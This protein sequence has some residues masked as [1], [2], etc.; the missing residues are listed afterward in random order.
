[1]NP[2]SSNTELQTDASRTRIRIDKNT[3]TCIRDTF[4]NKGDNVK[5]VLRRSFI[6]FQEKVNSSDR[7]LNAD[8]VESIPI[9]ICKDKHI[10]VLY[11]YFLYEVNNVT[12]VFITDIDFCDGDGG[13]GGGG[14]VLR[15]SSNSVPCD[16]VLDL[17][18][19]HRITRKLYRQIAALRGPVLTRCETSDEINSLVKLIIKKR[20]FALRKNQSAKFGDSDKYID[21]SELDNIESRL[22][23]DLLDALCAKYHFGY[24]KLIQRRNSKEKD[25]VSNNA[26]DRK[27]TSTGRVRCI[28]SISVRDIVGSLVQWELPG[29]IP[30][31]FDL[32]VGV[33]PR[34]E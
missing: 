26:V 9:Q 2:S 32:F 21:E 6:K 12:T 4:D 34:L 13:G 31:N 28:D 1:M 19:A 18:D 14:G 15:S 11:F 10:C 30:F 23:E 22:K 29:D 16:K 33:V 5:N 25:D 27:L 20:S 8:L 3:F 24:V 7:P 17:Y